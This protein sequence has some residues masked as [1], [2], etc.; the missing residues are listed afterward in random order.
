[1]W[2]KEERKQKKKDNITYLFGSLKLSIPQKRFVD[3]VR[4]L[5][6]AIAQSPSDPKG[7]KI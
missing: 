2:T 4:P 3:N 5:A 1:M 7:V 6:K